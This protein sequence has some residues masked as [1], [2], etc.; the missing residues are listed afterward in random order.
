MSTARGDRIDVIADVRLT[1]IERTD[2]FGG[3]PVDV[4]LVGGRIADIAPA[5][6]LPRSGAVLDGA[7][8]W[9]LPGLRDH[10][11]HTVQWALAAR[12]VS[13]EG[14]E[15]AA[16]A[17]AIMGAAP[18]DPEGRRVGSGFRDA[19]WPDAPDLALLDAATG[20]IPTYLINADVHSV[21]L[22]SA[23][24]RREGMASPDGIL[25]EEP[26]FEISRR[27]NALDPDFADAAVEAALRAAAA[28]GIVGIVDLDM[29]WNPE[30][31]DRR[32]RRGFDAVRVSFGVYAASLERAIAA[33]LQTGDAL[34]A[35][36]LVRMGPF[37]V[38]T[39]GSLGTRTAACAHHYPGAPHDFGVMTV[40]PTELLELMRRAAGAGIDCAVHAIGDVA[41]THALDA[42]ALAGASGTIEHAQLVAHAD[43]PRFAR[44]G[45]A[46]SVQPAH[47]VDDRDVAEEYW[48]E[49]TSIAYPLRELH[50]AGANLLFGSDAP[51][52]ALD[53][54]ATMAA[55]VF[56]TQGGREPW[57]PHQRVDA[58]TALA[59]STAGGSQTGAALAPGDV[60]DLVVVDRDPLV[61]DEAA[62][63]GTAVAATMIASRLTHRA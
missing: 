27:L 10:H 51:V 45:V 5:G 58:A 11:V 19:L 23:A 16:A 59:A 31:W 34:D 41:N 39:D 22:N 21:W 13:L 7:G 35:A 12:R 9:V 61:A 46:A 57:R 33:G 26:A 20:D 24:L 48:A 42:F 6:A 49:Q 40:P 2:P 60:A 36:G 30:S 43:I 8:G 4:H 62:L 38:I 56:R 3:E 17:A 28:R 54:W 50:D 53:P 55:G 1:G 29:A 37:K 14:A 63:R 18:A 47:A 15:T 44:L 52:A 25:R 32:L